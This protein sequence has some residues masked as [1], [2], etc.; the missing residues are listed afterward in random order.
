MQLLG[1]S[2]EDI[3]NICGKK[4]SLKTVCMLAEQMVNFVILYFYKL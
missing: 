4:F 1:K 2:L 3:F